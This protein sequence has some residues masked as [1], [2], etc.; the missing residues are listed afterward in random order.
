MMHRTFRL[1]I[2]N[3]TRR[4][5]SEVLVPLMNVLDDNTAERKRYEFRQVFVGLSPI[6]S[7]TGYDTAMRL[8]W[9]LDEEGLL[10]K[11]KEM[12]NYF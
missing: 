3:H 10:S 11:L 2:Y 9:I 6:E 4:D 1:A 12:F 8:R 7:S 5:G